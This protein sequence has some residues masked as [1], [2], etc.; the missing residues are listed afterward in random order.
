MKRK[1]LATADGHIE[2]LDKEHFDDYIQYMKTSIETYQPELFIYAGDGC[3]SRN[4]RAESEDYGLLTKYFVSLNQFCA[5]NNVEC[6]Y[7][8][9]TPSH[10]GDVIKRII[11]INKLNISYYEEP[12]LIY[13]RGTSILLLPEIYT[14]TIDSFNKIVRNTLGK[15]EKADICVFH[16]MFD[17]AIPQL[18][19]VDS[20]FNQSRSVVI[21]T[22]HF[23]KSFVN[24]VA[25]GGHVHKAIKDKDTNCLYLG[26]F[27]NEVHQ[28]PSSD[29]F[30]FKY[31]EVSSTEFKIKNVNNPYLLDMKFVDIKIHRDTTIDNIL[32]RCRHIKEDNN[33]VVY[34]VFIDKNNESRQTFKTWKKIVQPLHVKK[35]FI[36]ET[37]NELINEDVSK[38][39]SVVIDVNDLRS[40]S[41]LFYKEMTNTEISVDI[42]DQI[43]GKEII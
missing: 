18:K 32:E 11:E 2:R 40:M 22:S 12:K 19:Q 7:L 37:L 43:F 6:I 5:D 28:P 20:N 33:R 21:N 16:G 26:R 9:G 42:L 4:V 23:M 38:V 15:I 39:S 25:F 29:M 8:K 1:I 34:N 17:F 35:R 36:A 31:L 13:F 30:G 24:V 14:P 27:I 3:D 10:D 41:M